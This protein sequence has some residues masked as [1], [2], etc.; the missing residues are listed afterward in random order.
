M[1]VI[2]FPKAE[3]KLIINYAAGIHKTRVFP[4]MSSTEDW[5]FDP[6]TGTL[7]RYNGPDKKIVIPAE[8][9]GVS[10]TSIGNYAFSNN[11][12]TSVIIPNSVTSIKWWTFSNNRL[13]SAVIPDSITRIEAGAFY[14]NRLTSVALPERFNDQI[15][16]VFGIELTEFHRLNRDQLVRYYGRYPAGSVCKNSPGLARQ[17]GVTVINLL[18]PQDEPPSYEEMMKVCCSISQD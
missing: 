3:K 18:V 5:K 4:T 16:H 9:N 14:N 15:I 11:Q 6:D 1:P 17:F 13:T 10:V 8:I 7:L 2:L 12:L